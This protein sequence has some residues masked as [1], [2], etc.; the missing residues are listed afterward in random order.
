MTDQTEA[1]YIVQKPDGTP[2]GPVPHWQMVQWAAQGVI[3]PTTPVKLGSSADWQPA[4]QGLGLVFGGPPPQQAGQDYPWASQPEKGFSALDLV[5]P[6]RADPLAVLAGYL[7]LFSV[8]LIAAPISLVVGILAIK[9]LKK[10]P[11]KTGKGRAWFGLI[12]GVIFT[13]LL[14]WL[15]LDLVMRPR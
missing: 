5:A 12:M 14:L 1:T 10:H 3:S 11:G 13:P 2:I 15:V 6:V 9:S 8:I 7:G 4:G